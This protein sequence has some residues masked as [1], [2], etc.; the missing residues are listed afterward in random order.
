MIYPYQGS[1][2]SMQQLLQPF[3]SADTTYTTENFPNA[4]RANVAMTQQNQ[5]KLT[6]S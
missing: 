4:I 5:I 1:S 3:D 6:I 2:V